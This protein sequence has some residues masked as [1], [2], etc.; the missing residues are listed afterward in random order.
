MGHMNVQHYVAMF[1]QSTW[2]LLGLLGLTASYFKEQRRAMAAIEQRIVYKQELHAG[3]LVE[4]RSGVLEVRDKAIRFFHEMRSLDT[5][6]IAAR[7]EMVAVF[8]DADSRKTLPLPPEIRERAMNFP[9]R[10]QGSCP[11]S[12]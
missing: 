11:T 10:N 6:A 1:D 2:A 7:M 3:N 8:M 9:S 12:E 5:D 4:I